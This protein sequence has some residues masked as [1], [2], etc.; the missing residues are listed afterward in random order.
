MKESA[1]NYF[2]LRKYLNVNKLDFKTGTFNI[3][4][5]ILKYLEA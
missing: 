4:V 1:K 2:L 5:K 3:I